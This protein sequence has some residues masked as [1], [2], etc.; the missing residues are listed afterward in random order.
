MRKKADDSLTKVRL[1]ETG[2]RLFARYGFDATTT[3]MIAAE[4]GLNIATM[5]FHFGNKENF[6][7]QV[8]LD[9]AN[10]IRSYYEPLG[11]QVQSLREAGELDREKAWE[12][13][14]RYVDL[15]LSIVANMQ[16]PYT[17]SLLF[18]EQNQRLFPDRPITRVICRDAESILQTLLITYWGGTGSQTA[19]VV[20]RIVNGS[21]ITLGEHPMFIRRSLGLEDDAE[22]SEEVIAEIREYT[23]NSIR[24]YR[25]AESNV[26]THSG[27]CCVSSCCCLGQSRR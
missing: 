1:L 12:L 15:V 7:H 8:L 16:E 11:R 20:S 2:A 14:C 9:T 22:L 17:L 5:A 23:L 24:A 26:Q 13:I 4:A 27:A 21:L 25:P 6:F 18:H 10:H 3:R 19:V